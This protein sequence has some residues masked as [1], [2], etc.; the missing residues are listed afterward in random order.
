MPVYVINSLPIRI[1]LAEAKGYAPSV[2]ATGTVVTELL[3][4]LVRVVAE[5]LS[6]LPCIGV[7]ILLY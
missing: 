1:V 3:I 6:K 5:K 7:V 4:L 2:S